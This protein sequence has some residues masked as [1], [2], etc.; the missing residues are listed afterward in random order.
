MSSR[1]QRSFPATAGDSDFLLETYPSTCPGVP[2]LISVTPRVRKQE[3]VG[4]GLTPAVA[5][6]VAADLLRRADELD[7]KAAPPGGWNAGRSLDP[8]PSSRRSGT[9]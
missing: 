6:D 1:D 5:R 2:A 9:S 4:I 8:T 7:T 3:R